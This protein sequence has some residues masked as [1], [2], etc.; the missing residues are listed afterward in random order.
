MKN[1]IS[2]GLTICLGTGYNFLS[3]GRSCYRCTVTGGSL[4]HQ[5]LLIKIFEGFSLQK[6]KF[7]Y[8]TRDFTETFQMF[9]YMS[10]CH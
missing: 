9:F 8:Q 1:K 3:F 6:H 2:S 10:A 5:G 4:R 7:L